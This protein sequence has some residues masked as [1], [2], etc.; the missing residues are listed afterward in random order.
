MYLMNK[1]ELTE[2]IK[3]WEGIYNYLKEDHDKYDRRVAKLML[4]TTNHIIKLEAELKKR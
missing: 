1:E 4:L 2:E 3:E